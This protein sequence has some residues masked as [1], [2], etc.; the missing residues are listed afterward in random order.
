MTS[1]L[2]SFI[3][4]FAAL[5]ARGVFAPER[6]E[7]GRDS[8][9]PAASDVLG[10]GVEPPLDGPK[11]ERESWC[12]RRNGTSVKR[13]SASSGPSVEPLTGMDGGGVL[14]LDMTTVLQERMQ[15]LISLV[16]G[17]AMET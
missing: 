2:I 5:R 17:I 6:E 3:S 7:P 8:V 12:A 13:D 14:A 4:S 16:Q 1:H 11:E 9:E 10:L 15:C